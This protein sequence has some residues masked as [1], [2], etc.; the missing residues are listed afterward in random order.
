M[1]LLKIL[2]SLISQGSFT[3]SF[4]GTGSYARR[5][6]TASYVLG[7]AAGSSGTSGANGTSGSAAISYISLTQR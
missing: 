6:L 7:G 5:A 1:P 4:S 2:P 3:G